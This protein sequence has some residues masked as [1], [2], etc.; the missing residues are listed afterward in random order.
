M[1]F[2]AIAAVKSEDQFVSRGHWL[3]D[4]FLRDAYCL[5]DPF[6]TAKLTGSLWNRVHAELVTSSSEGVI[7]HLTTLAR[8]ILIPGTPD[9]TVALECPLG[10]A[11]VL[12]A[13]GTAMLQE[14]GMERRALRVLHLAKLF[15]FHKYNELGDLIQNT[16]WNVNIMSIMNGIKTARGVDAHSE[17]RLLASRALGSQLTIVSYCYYPSETKLPDYSRTNKEYYGKISGIKVVHHNKPFAQASHA[18]MNKLLAVEGALEEAQLNDW[19][20]WVDCD[21]YF[22]TRDFDVKAFIN[23]VPENKHIV[24]S[25][26]ANMLNSAVSFIRK[27]KWSNNFLKQVRNLLAAPSPFSFKDNPYHEQSPLM[28][29]VLVPTILDEKSETGYAEEVLLV[30]Q[31]MMNAYPEEI[32]NRSTFMQHAL[33]QEGD[34]I[35]SFNGC[36]SLLGGEYCENLWKSMFETSM[37]LLA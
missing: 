22:M 21:A 19:V 16:R 31:K 36:G 20:M 23:R 30:D 12:Q 34:W 25:E 4:K 11:A 9:P 2:L 6:A 7:K 28:F 15:A 26:D 5:E 8:S 35:I 13:L 27:S 29:L 14:K 18:W 10:T 32:A 3:P 33:Y 24:I 37:T 1:W 17:I